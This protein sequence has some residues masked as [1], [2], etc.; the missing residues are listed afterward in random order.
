MKGLKSRSLFWTFAGSFLLVLLAATLLQGFVIVTVVNS[1]SARWTRDRA[2]LLVK[3]VGTQ[4]EALGPGASESQVARLLRERSGVLILALRRADGRVILPWRFPPPVHRRIHRLLSGETDAP[5]D[6]PPGSGPPD[7]RQGAPPPDNLERPPRP[8]PLGPPV[9]W[10]GGPGDPGAQQFRLVTRQKLSGTG[11]ELAAF[12]PRGRFAFWPAGALQRLLLFL[13]IA[14]LLAGAAGTI[15]FRIL[16]RRLRALENLASRITAGDLEARVPEGADEIGM[17]GAQLN[18]MTEA[19]HRARGRVEA[20]DHERR[21]LLA[22][23]THE[24]ATPL[25][26]IRGYTQTLLDPSVAVTSE[27]RSLFLRNV[28][29][30]SERMDRLIGDLLDLSR[31]EAG[32]A[33]FEPVRLDWTALL[34]NTI[35]RFRPRFRDAGLTLEWRDPSR[36]AWIRADGRRIEQVI[37]NLLVNA[38]RYVPPGGSV[39]VSITGAPVEPD[40]SGPAPGATEAPKPYVRLTVTDDGPGLGAGDLPHLFDR[41]YR[42]PSARSHPGSG[43]GLA[44]VRE[45]VTRH[46]GRVHAG[47]VEPHGITISIDL[48]ASE[49]PD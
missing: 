44:I 41:F 36:E 29:E 40:G 8:G 24:L 26:S 5:E 35:E 48:P 34:R 7:D 14:F 18:R 9:E 31:L 10:R 47:L 39:V 20:T 12:M 13:P 27:E 32:V 11:G 46:G 25:T 22:D 3:E 21:R 28:L 15:V 23:I 2:D 37:E 17:L 38:L 6:G 42:A 1:L 4:V 30:E 49:T 45:I 19:L 43:L 16:I 33:E